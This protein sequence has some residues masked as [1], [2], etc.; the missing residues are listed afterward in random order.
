VHFIVAFVVFGWKMINQSRNSCSTFYVIEWD[1]KILTF[2]KN[3][4]K[5]HNFQEKCF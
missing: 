5:S 3:Y 4:N 2:D 1:N